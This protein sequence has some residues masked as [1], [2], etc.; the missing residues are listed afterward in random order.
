VCNESEFHDYFR[1]SQHSFN[2]LL[3]K[4]EDVVYFVVHIVYNLTVSNVNVFDK[5][6]SEG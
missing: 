4:M 5:C 3:H 2:V 1:M 6:I